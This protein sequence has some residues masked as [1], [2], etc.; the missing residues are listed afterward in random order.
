MTV[1]HDQIPVKGEA[2]RDVT[3]RFT[4]HGPVIDDD[5]AHGRAFALRTVWAQPGASGYFQSSWLTHAKSWADFMAAHD[6]WG[7]PPLNLVWADTLG[8]IGWAAS[9]LTPKRTNWDGLLPVPGDGRYEWAGF[10]TGDELPVSRNPAKGWF[11]TANEMN[12]PA[13]YPDETR[14]VSFEW[15]DRSRIDRI[16]DVLAA[17]A[18]VSV[19]DSMALQTDSHVAIARRLIALTA[20][21]TAPDPRAADALA[22]LKAWDGN[23][24]IGSVAAT[25]YEVWAMKHLG[26]AVVDALAPAARPVMGTPALDAILGTLEGKGS[27]PRPDPAA[28]DALLL[29]S[30]NAALDELTTRL[31]PDVNAWS[32]GRLHHATWSPAIATLADPAT[33][34]AM[35]VGPLSLPGGGQSP[36]AAHYNPAT[37]DVT[38]GASVRMVLDVGAWDNSVIINTPGQSGDV[39]SPHYGD[40]FPLWATGAYAPLLWTREA[41]DRQ[42]ERV[43]AL[44]PGG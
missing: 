22:R 36:K 18:H 30:L 15:G 10:L 28:R 31:G 5:P 11:A 37:F 27:G 4:R 6:H 24:T 42:A 9:G 41:V 20:P 40:L 34:T 29:V 14:K 35:T 13:D 43:I 39:A 25:I 26:P 19:A 32:W 23:E 12:L 38:A 17:N 44:T 3:L 1:V 2:P 33:A 21:L 16:D 7:A 8:Q